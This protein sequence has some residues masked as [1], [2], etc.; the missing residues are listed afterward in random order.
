MHKIGLPH[1]DWFEKTVV[2]FILCLFIFTRFVGLAYVS[3]SSMEPTYKDGS[4]VVM[5]PYRNDQPIKRGDVVVVKESSYGRLFIKR[6]VAL[7]GDMVCA[8][9][10]RLYVNGKPE[11]D[12]FP[13]FNDPGILSS[14]ITLGNDE[15]FI[16]GDN[17]PHSTDSRSFGPVSADDVIGIVFDS[18]SSYIRETGSDSGG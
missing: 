9:K 18:G 13:L 3:G 2:I 1:L 8:E 10:G 5:E 17:R 6:V 7:P 14:S 11:E 12:D 16:M 4:F 15:Y